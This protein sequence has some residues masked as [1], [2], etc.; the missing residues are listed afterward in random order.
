MGVG[1]A[2]GVNDENNPKRNRML[3]RMAGTLPAG[4]R[5]KPALG[6]LDLG[7]GS[8]GRHPQSSPAFGWWTPGLR[9][10]LCHT[11]GTSFPW[12]NGKTRGD[13]NYAQVVLAQSGREQF[14]SWWTDSRWRSQPFSHVVRR[15]PRTPNPKPLPPFLAW[16]AGRAMEG[17]LRFPKEP[18]RLSAKFHSAL[19]HFQ[20]TGFVSR[21]VSSLR[22]H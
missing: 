1:G 22:R 9:A 6:T 14:V 13:K 17:R 10:S 21:A 20:F 19:G 16:T 18:L 12:G 2:G 15:D 8:E 4:A 5:A 3:G 11:L 7:L